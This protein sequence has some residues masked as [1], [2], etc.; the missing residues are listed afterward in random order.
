MTTTRAKFEALSNNR[1]LLTVGDQV[2]EYWCPMNGG[3]VRR[4]DD[5]HPGTLGWQV[6]L[7]LTGSGSTLHISDPDKRPLIDLIRKEW[8]RG[9]KRL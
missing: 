7:G 9:G 8:R 3:Y 6:C 1:V 4:V 5:N 2:D